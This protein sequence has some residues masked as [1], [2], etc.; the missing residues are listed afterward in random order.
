MILQATGG[1]L[2]HGHVLNID[3]TPKPIPTVTHF[4]QQDHLI[5]PLPVSLW[6]P[7]TFELPH[8]R[9]FKVRFI[10]FSSVLPVCLCVYMHHICAVLV[11]ARRGPQDPWNWS[12][13]WCW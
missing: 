3:E 2:R 12:F 7:I 10:L 13:R 6:G 9:F 5:V 4:P 11:K 8:K 1:K